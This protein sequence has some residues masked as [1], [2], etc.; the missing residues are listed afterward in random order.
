MCGLRTS[1]IKLQS[2]NAD[3]AWS[4]LFHRFTRPH[5]PETEIKRNCRRSAET[6]PDRRQFCFISVLFH[7]ERRA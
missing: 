2:N 5:I 4:A 1:E 7:Y 6:E 3:G